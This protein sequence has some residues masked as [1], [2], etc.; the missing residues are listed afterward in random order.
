MREGTQL[1]GREAPES[2]KARRSGYTQ[3]AAASIIRANRLG[4]RSGAAVEGRL[5]CD[6]DT[7]P[8]GQQGA[9][10]GSRQGVAPTA[11]ATWRHVGCHGNDVGKC[12]TMRRTDRST[13]TA[14]LSSR[15]RSVVTCA[16][17]QAVPAA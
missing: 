15:S 16:V 12:R 2:T 11:Q 4:A 14:T 6:R 5:I 7:G 1:R 3:V 9:E 10:R 17:A 8:W 13:H